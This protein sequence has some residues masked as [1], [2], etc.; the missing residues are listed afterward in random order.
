MSIVGGKR[1]SIPSGAH[2]SAHTRHTVSPLISLQSRAYSDGKTRR[3]SAPIAVGVIRTTVPCSVDN[4]NTTCGPPDSTSPL[5]LKS[6]PNGQ[7]S[8]S[9]TAT[10]LWH[11]SGM[12][13]HTVDCTAAKFVFDRAVVSSKKDGT[14]ESA[15]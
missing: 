1:Q 9:A 15:T 2:Y 14:S 11:L 3:T 8:G 4:M 5:F 10:V 7:P 6:Y 12:F 13:V